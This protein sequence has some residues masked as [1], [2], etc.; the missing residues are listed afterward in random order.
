MKKLIGFSLVAA[1]CLGAWYYTKQRTPKGSVAISGLDADELAAIQEQEPATPTL[2]DDI[3][4]SAI[5]VSNWVSPRGMEYKPL[6]NTVEKKY[7]IPNGLLFRQAY[8]ESHFRED[9]ISGKVRSP[10][11]AVGIMQIVPKYHPELGEAGALNVPKA[12]DYAGKIL[13]QWHRQF[14]SW[15]LA[16]AAYNAGPGNVIK[17]NGIPPFEETQKYVADITNDV[18]VYV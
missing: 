10:A 8:Q 15:K 7:G 14:S 12:V 16:L 9:I 3:V 4:N 17:Y 2:W 6:F 1:A 11:G 5:D 13:S 18:Q